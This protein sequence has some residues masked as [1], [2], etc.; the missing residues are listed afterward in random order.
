MKPQFTASALR[1]LIRLRA[2]I[3]DKNP[4]AEHRISHRLRQS[5]ERIA[6]QPEMAVNIEGLPGIQDLVA[7]DYILR[8]TALDQ[9]IDS[10]RIWH[11]KE[12]R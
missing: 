7:S 6:E 9:E 10:L 5:I 12:Y 4:A 8:Y 3:A 2:F 11:G 1:D